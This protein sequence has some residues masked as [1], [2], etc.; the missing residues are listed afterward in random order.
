MF[1]PNTSIEVCPRSDFKLIPI[2]MLQKKYYD[3]FNL[4]SSLVTPYLYYY[5]TSVLKES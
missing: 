4:K 2:A 5:I 3:K 1:R